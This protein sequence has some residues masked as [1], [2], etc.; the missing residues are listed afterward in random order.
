[1]T[2]AAAWNQK[3]KKRTAEWNAMRYKDVAGRRVK[4]NAS[5]AVQASIFWIEDLGDV[6]EIPVQHNLLVLES[7]EAVRLAK[8]LLYMFG[9][10]GERADSSPGD[11]CKQCGSP[12][13]CVPGDDNA[14]L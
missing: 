2:R 13:W 8:W 1:M 14:P 12:L 5:H 6:V 9:E 11:V 4:R 7:G 10:P 3:E